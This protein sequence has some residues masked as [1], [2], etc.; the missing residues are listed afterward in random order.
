MAMAQDGTIQDAIIIRRTITETIGEIF[1]SR[2]SVRLVSGGRWRLCTIFVPLAGSSNLGDQPV[3][4]PI[5][6]REE[7]RIKGLHFWQGTPFCDSIQ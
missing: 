1:C 6:R 7:V 2:V 4:K 3:L 5:W